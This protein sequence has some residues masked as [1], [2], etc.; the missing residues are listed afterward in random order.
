MKLTINAIEQHL[1]LT[2][3]EIVSRAGKSPVTRP[4][5]V[6]KSQDG[7]F[8]DELLPGQDV[9]ITNGM[10]FSVSDALDPNAEQEPDDEITIPDLP[11]NLT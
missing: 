11:G 2:Y 10:V 6:W 5:V 1:T 7:R 3:D 9:E 8:G 4:V